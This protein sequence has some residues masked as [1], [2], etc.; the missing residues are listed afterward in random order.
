[1]LVIHTISLENLLILDIET[2]P[3]T[4]GFQEL[5]PSF[6]ELWLE[7]FTK[8]APDSEDPGAGYA[9]RSGIYA[10]FGKII[11]ISAG[12][13][14]RK[15]G[16]IHFRIKSFAS[17]DE[18]GLIADF[19]EAVKQFAVRLPG[20][21]FC[22]HNI[23]EFDIPYICRRAIVNGL[24]LPDQ[25]TFYGKKPWEISLLDTLHLWRF[26][27]YKNYTSLK[28]LAGIL[29]VP[30]PKD[31]IDG[32]RVAEVYWKERNLDRIVIYCQKDVLTVA[33]LLLRFKGLPLLNEENTEIV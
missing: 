1:M 23:R 4:S 31:D 19:F 8:I 10:E 16:A 12:Y 22:G 18:A 25:L 13:F 14:F 2:V 15:E 29:N 24:A 20:L 9:T 11:C 27:D 6:Q 7:K 5:S 17:H 33:Q 28:L 3:G 26:G 30:T 21:T 32:S